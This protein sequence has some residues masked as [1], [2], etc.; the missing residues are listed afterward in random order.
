MKILFVFADDFPYYGACTNILNH[1]LS[2]GIFTEKAEKIGVL[3]AKY[4][5]E[6]KNYEKTEFADVYRAYVWDVFPLK[7][8]K[9]KFSHPFLFVRGAFAKIFSLVKNKLFPYK[10]IKSSF[11]G[12]IYKKLKKINA[13][14]NDIIVAVSGDFNI[15]EAVRR[16]CEKY[17]GPKFVIHQVDP[18]SNNESFMPETLS[19]C[20]EIEEKTFAAADL[21]FTTPLIYK[22]LTEKYAPFAGKIQVLE[23]PNVIRPAFSQNAGKE[24]EFLFTGSLYGGIRNPEY[25]FK[26]IS[27]AMTD[28]N[29]KFYLVGV[30]EK[31]VGFDYNR[32]KIVC[33]GRKSIDET[34]KFVSRSRYLV[35]IGNIMKNQVPSK[36]FDYVSTGKP[37]IN[38]CKNRDCFSMEYLKNYP[39]VINLFEDESLFEEQV[40]ALKEFIAKNADAHVDFDDVKE[41]Y[42]ECTPEFCARRM[43]DGFCKILD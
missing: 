17:P 15:A 30:A 1:L 38:V 7:S 33:A 43:L 27:A 14:E 41:L 20:A 11:C 5:F 24:I 18:C 32:R 9:N 34:A 29:S 37:I 19:E 26:L 8:H 4:S 31:D 13:R 42:R 10:Y 36:L 23:F 2:T 39:F 35:N 25:T 16:Y 28:E 6:E 3:S 40:A 22:Y 21:V 12:S